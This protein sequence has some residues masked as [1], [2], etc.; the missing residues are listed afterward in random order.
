MNP[1]V[2]N[3]PTDS[4]NKFH[5]ARRG[6]APQSWRIPWLSFILLTLLFFGA[7]HDVR[8]S[9]RDNTETPIED[10]IENLAE[11]S[12][13]R[14]V[15]FALLGLFGLVALVRKGGLR[16]HARWPSAHL[17]LF[18]LEFFECFFCIHQVCLLQLKVKDAFKLKALSVLKFHKDLINSS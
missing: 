2:E 5:R 14:R 13:A 11:G 7:L 8:F 16:M 9:L 18:F 4:S 10:R 1:V 6:I 12:I 15:S 3:G 17:I